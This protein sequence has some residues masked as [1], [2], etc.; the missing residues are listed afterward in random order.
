MFYSSL[1]SANRPDLRVTRVLVENAAQPGDKLENSLNNTANSGYT[2][3]K[4]NFPLIKLRT[5]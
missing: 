2:S 3:F 5:S 4:L 1:D